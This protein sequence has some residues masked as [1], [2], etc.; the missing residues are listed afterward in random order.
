MVN[1]PGTP[2]SSF[3][4]VVVNGILYI[5]GGHVGVSHQYPLEAFSN[6]AH[7]VDLNSGR[8]RV[9]PRAP[10][11]A[12]GLRLTAYRDDIFLFGG[13]RHEPGLDF[14]PGVPWLWY[15][16]S[17]NETWAYSL[18]RNE[19]RLAATIP[20]PRSSHVAGTVGDK[21]YLIGGW[22][23]T[24]WQPGDID[25]RF[26]ATVEIFDL[27]GGYFIASNVLIPAPKRR[28]FASATMDNKI[29][30]ACGLGEP[31]KSNPEGD[32][33]DEFTM[34]DPVANQWRTSS[35]AELPSL[36]K[37]LFSPGMCALNDVLVVMGGLDNKHVYNTEVFLW[38][39]GATA[40]VTNS[41]TIP[42]AVT[43]PELIPLENGTVL[44]VGGH[45]Q[46]L[47]AGLWEVIKIDAI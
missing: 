15:A 25:G 7:A 35:N 43:F 17:S 34:Y 2:R 46:K 14:G 45:G 32:Y 4:Q 11:S 31:T 47:P 27:T 33:Y 8:I 1:F 30:T 3:G 20:R 39:K 28:A 42:A 21:T 23:G 5:G 12:E 26:H 16:R 24:P 44:V 10:Y 18:T 41:K 13:F 36:P 6:E 9:L 29:W 19:W 37:K 22:D 38:K 40:W